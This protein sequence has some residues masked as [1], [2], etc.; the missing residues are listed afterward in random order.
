[1]CALFLKIFAVSIGYSVLRI[2]I[3]QNFLTEHV[4]TKIVSAYCVLQTFIMLF[5]KNFLWNWVFICLPVVAI[6]CFVFSYSKR[7]EICFRYEFP[8]IITS[9]ILQMKMGRGLRKSFQIYLESGSKRYTSTL[10]YIY[11]N[12]VFLPQEIDKKMTE[13]SCFVRELIIEFKK[14]D[15]STHKSIEKLEN[16]RRRLIILNEF[17][18]RSGRIRGQVQLQAAVLTFI[19]VGCFAMMTLLFNLLAHPQV[20]LISL[21]LYSIGALG[22]FLM[23]NK[24]KWS[25]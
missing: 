3:R 25:I 19:Y 12:V 6:L 18:R 5:V 10:H 9:L 22:I 2:Y 4:M 21:L 14:I 15:Q 16:F 1:M 17:R 7:Q 13:Q 11:D 23:G 20:L 24:I 8:D